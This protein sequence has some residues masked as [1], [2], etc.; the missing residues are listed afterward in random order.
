MANRENKTKA[1]KLSVAAFIDAIAD[2]TRRADAATRPKR[3]RI[4]IVVSMQ[5]AMQI[6]RAHV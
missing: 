3:R 4:A 5:R 6:G 1:T 2:E